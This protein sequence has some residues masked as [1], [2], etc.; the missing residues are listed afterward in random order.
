[1][2]IIISGENVADLLPAESG[3]LRV[4][5]GGGPANTAVAVARLG[6]EVSFAARF[7]SDAFG[8]AFRDR[9]SAAGVDLSHA[10]RVEAPS[11]LAVASLDA[12]GAASYDFW[13]N[14]AADFAATDLP[15]PE[16]GDIQHIGSLAAYWQ[17]GADVAERWITDNP[18]P[19]TVT[20]TLDVNLRPLVLERQPDAITRLERLVQRA[21][22]VKASDDDLHL[23][24]PN[25][26]PAI[27]ARTWLELE[28]GP[29]L[30]VL[31]LGAGGVLGLTRD[32][33]RVHVP[34]PKVDVVDT[35]GAGDAAMGALLTELASSSVAEVCDNL[36]ATLRFT[37]AVAAL[38]CTK[39]GAYAPTADEVAAHFS[40]A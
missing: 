36:E 28:Q 11:S 35:I 17:P 37:V 24:Y 27:T 33:R 15:A 25:T 9:L 32:A 38:A 34:A 18:N 10:A 1:M 30:V 16:P 13:L 26:D 14:G 39:A 4:A 21:D 19:G 20:V 5:L 23:A 6:G 3:R 2:T 29:S 8:Q 40:A 12:S 22:V 31:T 7:G